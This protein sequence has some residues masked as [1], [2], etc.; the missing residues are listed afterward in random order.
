MCMG[1]MNTADFV[2]TG[3]ILGAASVRVGARR[4]L[5]APGRWASKVTDTEA[6][7]FVASL[8]PHTGREAGTEL[9]GMPER[10]PAPT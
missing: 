5:S 2:V 9:V 7:D 3:G 8:E 1:C 10:A 4:L 6:A